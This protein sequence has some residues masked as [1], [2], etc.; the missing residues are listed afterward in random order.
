MR[1]CALFFLSGALV[2]IACGCASVRQPTPFGMAK[3][4]TFCKNVKLPE[5][6][7][8]N[9]VSN[10]ASNQT[11]V[12]KGYNSSV[13]VEAIEAIGA[14]CGIAVGNALRASGMVP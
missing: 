8:S 12:V 1:S 9:S 5:M 11:L 3:A 4:D 13:N 10:G 7:M 14:A 6:Q 2:L